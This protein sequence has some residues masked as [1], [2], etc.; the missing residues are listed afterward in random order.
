TPDALQNAFLYRVGL[1]QRELALADLDRYERLYARK[2]AERAAA[3]FWTRQQLLD[4][5]AARREHAVDYLARYRSKGGLD[6]LIVAEVTIAQIDWRRSC[7]EPLLH[8]L[9]VSIER[10]DKSLVPHR[11]ELPQYTTV[12]VHKR[13]AKLAQQAQERLRSAV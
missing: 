2:H 4:D 9:C 3:V 10:H 7:P 11:C 6:R 1:S 12:T 13:N 5:D 8:D